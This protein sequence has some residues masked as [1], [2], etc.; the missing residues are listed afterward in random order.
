MRCPNCGDEFEGEACFCPTCGAEVGATNGADDCIANDIR[1]Q[2]NMLVKYAT[3]GTLVSLLVGIFILASALL[4][5]VDN[6]SGYTHPLWE[7][8]LY[9]NL[10]PIMPLCI[11][12]AVVFIVSLFVMIKGKLNASTAKR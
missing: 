6:E 9:K 2:K 4:K 5:Q 8:R 3:I 10:M 1:P 12:I 11:I 7:V